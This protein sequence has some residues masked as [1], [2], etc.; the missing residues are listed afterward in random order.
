MLKNLGVI[1][2]LTST[3][4]IDENKQQEKSEPN[5]NPTLSVLESKS[6]IE[7]IKEDE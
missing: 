6:M 4:P 5:L 2:N 1:N 3:Y 7:I